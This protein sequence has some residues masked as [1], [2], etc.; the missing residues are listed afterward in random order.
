M[1]VTIA[2]AASTFIATTLDWR[3]ALAQAAAP[4]TARELNFDA[5]IAEADFAARWR[6]GPL[7]RMEA[8]G[9]LLRVYAAAT[10]Y[11]TAQWQDRMQ[12]AQ[13]ADA[14]AQ[15]E[16]QAREDR[17]RARRYAED[18]LALAHHIRTRVSPSAFQSG[19]VEAGI[20]VLMAT[21]EAGESGAEVSADLQR[22]AVDALTLEANRHRTDESIVLQLLGMIPT[23]PTPQFVNYLLGPLRA[24]PFTE[25]WEGAASHVMARPDF[26]PF[27][28]SVREQADKDVDSGTPEKWKD[29]L[30]PEILRLVAYDAASKAA[31]DEAA[32]QARRA[33]D[34]YRQWGA[35]LQ[36]ATVAALVEESRYRLLGHPGQPELA[37]K[38]SAEAMKAVPRIG[39]ADLVEEPILIEQVHQ[40]LAALEEKPAAELIVR[41]NP[42]VHPN[43]VPGLV[44]RAYVGLVHRVLT[45]GPN[46]PL[47]RI[48][49]WLSR[50]VELAPQDP[51]PLLVLCRILHA[52]QRDEELIGRLKEVDALA[53]DPAVVNRFVEA[54][55]TMRDSPMLRM[56]LAARTAVPTTSS[57]PVTTA[58][59]PQPDAAP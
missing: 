36:I 57:A 47:E 25:N 34:G 46:P 38:V 7:R 44:S 23:A 59:A 12:R 4:R 26:T 53:G 28:V 18:G 19:V 22:R 21:I 49:R 24:G 20:C 37:A 13:A 32:N 40:H 16:S 48:E 27:L 15:I 55:L 31:F 9:N 41:L 51:E 39:R 11:R 50:A 33:A 1:L 29:A 10:S 17:R 5:A 3:A 58:P 43:L 54:A 6:L 14:P 35:R 8:A 52:T 45:A 56:F 30:S 2:V 42:G